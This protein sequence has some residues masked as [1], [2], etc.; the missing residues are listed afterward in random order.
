MLGKAFGLRKKRKKDTADK[1]AAPANPSVAPIG[2]I[3]KMLN[4]SGRI[5]LQT[6]QQMTQ[7]YEKPEFIRFMRQPALIGSSIQAGSFANPARTSSDEVNRT[8]IFEMD[9]AEEATSASETLKH[10]IYPLVTR[11]YVSGARASFSIGRVG[12]NDMIMPDLAISKQHAFIEIQR[13]NYLIRDVNSTNGT[14]V[15]GKRVHKKPKQI[16]DGD[17]I[18]F[19]RY[20]FSFL[21][22]DSLFDMLQGS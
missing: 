9:A 15:N 6:L 18:G 20:E 14:T 19:A 2:N 3:S 13:G 4:S 5:A 8:I 1:G 12:G 17:I 11:E 21:F 22:P 7:V 16:Q 10:A